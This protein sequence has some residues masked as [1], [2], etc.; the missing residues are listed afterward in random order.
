MGS[1]GLVDRTPGPASLDE[2]CLARVDGRASSP[3]DARLKGPDTS[4]LELPEAFSPIAF[5]PDEALQ[6]M[7]EAIVGDATDEYAFVIKDLA[8]GRGV[9]HNADR[10]FN[11]ASTFKLWVMYEVFRQQSLGLFDW[12]DELVVTPYYDAFA[13]SPRVTQLCQVLTV[14]DALDA[15]LSVSDNAAAV[16]LQDLVGAPN[17]N[18]S[19]AALG[20]MQSGLFTDGLPITAEDLALLLEAIARGEAVSR[21]ASADMLGLMAREGIDNGLAGGVPAEAVVAHKTGNWADAT[22]DA[23]IVYAPFGVYVFV[24]LTD[25][26]YET[27]VIR[28][29]SEAAYEYFRV[30]RYE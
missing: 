24:A 7:V 18:E 3:D 14:A 28:A 9:V 19:I 5:E 17:I 16:L 12:D 8:T 4:S 10:L 11:A 22:H 2:D 6:E 21:E 15:M 1:T 30:S 26:G 13:L 25:N 23:G 20:V 29:V 27:A